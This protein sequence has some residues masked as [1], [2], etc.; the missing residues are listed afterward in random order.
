MPA[1]G[2]GV[3]RVEPGRVDVLPELEHDGQGCAVEVGPQRG[4]PVLGDDDA[5]AGVR[6]R[7]TQVEAA[8]VEHALRVPRVGLGERAVAA[9]EVLGRR[10]PRLPRPTGQRQEVRHHAGPRVLLGQQPVVG[11]ELDEVEVGDVTRPAE[12]DVGEPR[13]VVDRAVLLV[14][15]AAPGGELER[16]RPDL[17][18]RLA[19]RAEGPPVRHRATPVGLDDRA[20][21]V[22][23]RDLVGAG[24]PEHLRDRRVRVPVGEGV[25]TRQE[26]VEE[27]RVPVAVEQ[28][29]EA[30]VAGQVEEVGP[31]LEH[32]ARLDLEHRRQPLGLERGGP[33][34]E[35]GRGAHRDVEGLPV[36]ELP[37]GV[38]QAHEGLVGDVLGRPDGPALGEVVEQPRRDGER[39]LAPVALLARGD[40]VHDGAHPGGQHRVTRDGDLAGGRGEPVPDEVPPHGR[41]RRLPA[42]V[43]VVPDRTVAPQDRRASGEAGLDAV[44][45]QEVVHL[46]AQQ[47]VATEPVP[48][49]EEAVVQADRAE[50]HVLVGRVVHVA[51]SGV[52][53]RRRCPST[54]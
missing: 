6:R 10:P 5:R 18:G 16:G 30:V 8:Q 22:V 37:R 26:R 46:E 15:L 20:P 12:E 9:P 4:R 50:V 36:T 19:T 31:G 23:P 35:P 43:P 2:R 14:L 24:G 41:S 3:V 42:P 38:D 34:V 29:P 40:P 1:P 17:P 44:V 25:A 54:P 45:L 52:G 39:P 11:V 32:P 49:L 53:C 48:V 13:H 21:P 7:A 51:P 28:D 47:V 33:A 27:G